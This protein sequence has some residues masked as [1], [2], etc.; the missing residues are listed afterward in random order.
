LSWL[1]GSIGMATAGIAHDSCRRRVAVS[2]APELRKD[3]VEF[4]A[5]ENEARSLAERLQ[6]RAPQSV[7]RPPFDTDVF[8]RFGATESS[9]HAC[10]LSAIMVIADGARLGAL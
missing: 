7:E 8:H 2:F 3:F 5:V 1:V 9:L 10:P 4:L 6:A